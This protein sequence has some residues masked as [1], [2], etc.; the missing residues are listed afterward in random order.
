MPPTTTPVGTAAV[1]RPWPAAAGLLL[2]GDMEVKGTGATGKAAASGPCGSQVSLG[3]ERAARAAVGSLGPPPPS[4]SM[5]GR[6][7]GGGGCAAGVHV[8][9]GPLAQKQ[10]RVHAAKGPSAFSRERDRWQD[11]TAR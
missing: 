6:G 7:G 4:G 1:P 11:E 9:L 5:V 3:P 8:F 2:V 10:S